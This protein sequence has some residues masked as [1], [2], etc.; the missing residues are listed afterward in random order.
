MQIKMNFKR[1]LDGFKNLAAAECSKELFQGGEGRPSS[2]LMSLLV[3][4]A[5]EKNLAIT[6]TIISCYCFLF[7]C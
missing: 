1:V 3:V 4:G 6:Q 2:Y 5:Y 7:Q